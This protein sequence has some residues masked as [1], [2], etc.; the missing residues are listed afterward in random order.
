[1]RSLS[2][3]GKG[4]ESVSCPDNEKITEDGICEKCPDYYTHSE[5]KKDCIPKTCSLREKVTAIAYCEPCP[6][7]TRA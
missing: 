5:D 3:N 1:M 4:C 2:L 6:D 7:Y